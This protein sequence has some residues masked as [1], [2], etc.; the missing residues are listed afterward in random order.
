MTPTTWKYIIGILAG[1]FLMFSGAFLYNQFAATTDFYPAYQDERTKADNLRAQVIDISEVSAQWQLKYLA[2]VDSIT[3][4][5]LN[6]IE[7]TNTTTDIITRHENLPIDVAFLELRDSLRAAH[8][9][10]RFD[11]TTNLNTN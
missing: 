4:L 8:N 3:T 6:A 11:Y 1:I 5:Q 10:P 9:R 2:I 7:I